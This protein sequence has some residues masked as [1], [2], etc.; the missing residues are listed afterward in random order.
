[1]TMT[2]I[3]RGLVLDNFIAPT[4]G[5]IKDAMVLIGNMVVVP[6]ATTAQTLPFS[7]H[8]EGVFTTVKATGAA[9]AIGQVLYWD[10]ANSNWVTAQSATA[11][12]AGFAAAAALTG[13]VVGT[14]KLNN[15]GAAVNVA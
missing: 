6:I 7:A 12:R 1:M 4:G 15:I 10:T 3:Q 8:T 9:W 11:R 2:F 13:D 5:V 14:V